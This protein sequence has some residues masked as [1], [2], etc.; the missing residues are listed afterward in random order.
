VEKEEGEIKS[1][2][3][4]GFERRKQPRFSAGLPIEYCRMN[5]S[6]I[7]PGHSVNVSEDGLMVSL[8]EQIDIGENL[9]MRL[10]FSWGADLN[11]IRTIVQVIWVANEEKKDGYYRCGVNFIDISPEDMDR[12][13][14]F[15][16]L[17]AEPKTPA[18]FK[19][20]VAG[21]LNPH[22]IFSS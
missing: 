12:L 14:S 4:V 11:I 9:D 13:K 7:L 21:C 15:L 8:P 19:D 10:Y 17:Y 22:K 20:S 6:K 1:G 2:P 16:D 5:S 3:L 18:E